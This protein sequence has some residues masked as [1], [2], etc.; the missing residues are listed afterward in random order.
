MIRTAGRDQRQSLNL[1]DFALISMA[2]LR[3]ECLQNR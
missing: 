1:S 2:A 3:S